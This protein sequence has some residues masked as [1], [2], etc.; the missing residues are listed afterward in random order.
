M[1]GAG[2][3]QNTNNEDAKIDVGITSYTTPSVTGNVRIIFPTVTSDPLSLYDNTTG[4]YT[5]PYNG[6]YTLQ[7]SGSV[8]ALTGATFIKV[9]TNGNL[10]QFGSVGYSGCIYGNL[11]F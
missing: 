7:L 2:P 6:Q 4:V 8:S 5:A 10:K 11:L 3:V 1:S 9:S